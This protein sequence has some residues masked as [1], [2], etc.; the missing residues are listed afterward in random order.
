[1]EP[2]DEIPYAWDPAIYVKLQDKDGE[3]PGFFTTLQNLV[4][5]V[6]KHEFYRIDK[7]YTEEERDAE[8]V[9]RGITSGS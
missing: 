1:M 4:H 9:R 7:V 5:V 2:K 6:K 8:A 3:Y